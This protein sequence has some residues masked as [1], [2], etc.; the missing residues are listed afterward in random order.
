MGAS[1]LLR[2][3][4]A[5]LL[6]AV[7]L[8]LSAPARAEN[9]PPDPPAGKSLMQKRIDRAVGKAFEFLRKSQNTTKGKPGAWSVLEPYWEP[10]FTSLVLF[11]SLRAGMDRDDPMI[12]AGFK[13]LADNVAA[14]TRLS[15]MYTYNIATEM[16]AIEAGFGEM[17]R[18]RQPAN[19]VEKQLLAI[20]EANFEYC[21]RCLKNGEAGY[22]DKQLGVD[23]SN[24][25]FV[26][27]ALEA[28]HRAGYIA[29]ATTWLDILSRAMALQAQDGPDV[30]LVNILSTRA[31]EVD[32][33]G[34]VIKD[35]YEWITGKPAKAR[36][37]MYDQGGVC[38]K[39]QYYGSMT[40]A[41][42]AN[43]LSC[44]FVLEKDETFVK[45]HE[46]AFRTA[47][48]DGF[49][50]LQKYY[51]V[52]ANPCEAPFW[53]MQRKYEGDT[54]HTYYFLFTLARITTS[55][56]IRCIGTRNWFVEG[57]DFLLKSQQPNGSWDQAAHETHN[58]ESK[59]IP[60]V[61]TSFA[62]WF[63]SSLD[64]R[65]RNAA[66][67]RAAQATGVEAPPANPNL[68]RTLTQMLEDS[69]RKVEQWDVDS[70]V[71]G[72]AEVLLAV[73]LPPFHKDWKPKECTSSAA[74][75]IQE[76]TIPGAEAMEQAV[77][78][79]K[80]DTYCDE[81]Y[82]KHLLFE[83]WRTATLCRQMTA[84]VAHGLDDK[85]WETFAKDGSKTK[86]NL[87]AGAKKQVNLV[88]K[89]LVGHGRKIGTDKL[90]WT[91][92][93]GRPAPLQP[94][95]GN[96]S[97]VLL[98][99]HVAD[100]CGVTQPSPVWDAAVRF[101]LTT[102]EE[103]G[104]ETDLLGPDGKP[105]GRKAT[106]RGFGLLPGDPAEVEVTM[107]ALAALHRAREHGKLPGK[108]KEEVEKAI[109]DA[110]A[111]LQ[112]NFC[113]YT[114]FPSLVSARRLGAVTGREI[115][116]GLK[117]KEEGLKFIA[118]MDSKREFLGADCTRRI[119]CAFYFLSDQ[120]LQ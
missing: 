89:H 118:L 115:L 79:I 56:N 8:A 31:D 54:F 38:M 100:L 19:A 80:A 29:P 22:D 105:A 33:H 61:D 57:T 21:K 41:G 109:D 86:F 96:T 5:V 24:T 95:A 39:G 51:A 108:L 70:P 50:W 15:E 30:P 37:W 68:L 66:G 94:D 43:L 76:S 63:F 91:D 3:V 113:G 64:F 107:D 102:Q 17:L 55:T 2:A 23:L 103:G 14:G 46:Q 119:A 116:G 59:S 78:R 53:T 84:I 40:C 27:M 74:K 16:L 71:D 93:C 69:H 18:S 58:F 112:T 7:A 82:A 12:R 25:Q 88:A 73:S 117:W 111:W 48:R 98:T 49:A 10:G 85:A 11:T 104:P 77:R 20:F 83:R 90:G 13:Y 97:L 6:P 28:A 67:P 65:D 44:F 32:K 114:T 72:T 26:V 99:L 1:S 47:L 75:Y 4:S 42:L 120:V 60:F 87:P 35:R 36:G 62:L 9:K 92:S 34:Y 110:F 106:A 52:N 101:L 81:A 45:K